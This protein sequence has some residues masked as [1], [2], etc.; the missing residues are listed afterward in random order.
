[1]T[2]GGRP[3]NCSV[4]A[5]GLRNLLD[6]IWPSTNWSILNTLRE[7]RCHRKVLDRAD[8]PLNFGRRLLRKGPEPMLWH[9]PRPPCWLRGDRSQPAAAPAFPCPATEPAT[10]STTATLISLMAIFVPT[11]NDGASGRSTEYRGNSAS[12]GG[13]V[14]IR[15]ER[16]ATFGTRSSNLQIARMRRRDQRIEI[17][18]RAEYRIDGQIVCA[19]TP[20]AMSADCGCSRIARKRLRPR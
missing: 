1:V 5:R 11:A 6:H 14:E 13:P 19:S 17:G 10:P 20:C 7:S 8:L 16:I 3:I 15:I 4:T 12:W 9:F 2:P 18:A